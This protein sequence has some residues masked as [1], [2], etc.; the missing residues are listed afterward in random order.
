MK[1]LGIIN[2]ALKLPKF[3]VI[4]ENCEEVILN[5]PDGSQD[6]RVLSSYP[7]R[8]IPNPFPGSNSHRVH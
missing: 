5:G 2:D 4:R 8:V 1:F 3:K 6:I 7:S